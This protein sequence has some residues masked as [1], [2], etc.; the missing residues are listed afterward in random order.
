MHAAIR[1]QLNE[2][3][4]ELVHRFQNFGEDVYRALRDRCSVDIDEIDRATQSFTVRD[5]P[6]R[7]VGLVVD[8]IR[9]EI[10]RHHFEGS[11]TLIR[12][13]RPAT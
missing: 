5:I 1:I 4:A 2:P 3:D 7:N 6:R 10:R 11:T 9:R 12:L 13:D 8:T